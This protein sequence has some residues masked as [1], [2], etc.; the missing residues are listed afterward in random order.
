M[1]YKLS[2]YAIFFGGMGIGIALADNTPFQ[3]VGMVIAI[4]SLL[5]GKETE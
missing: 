5:L 1:P 3:L 4:A 2:R